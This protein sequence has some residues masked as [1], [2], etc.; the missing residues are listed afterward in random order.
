MKRNIKFENNG[1]EIEF[2]GMTISDDLLISFSKCSNKDFGPSPFVYIESKDVIASK[3]FVVELPK[4]TIM[5]LKAIKDKFSTKI[6]SLYINIMNG[7]EEL[8]LLDLDNKEYPYLTTTKTI[9]EE[10]EIS[11]KYNKALEFVFSDKCFNHYKL[12]E[13][14]AFKD[15]SD[16]Q[17]RIS[18]TAKGMN[19]QEY[20]YE[21]NK[22][23]YTTFKELI[24]RI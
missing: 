19:L 9:L 3:K 24:G 22:V 8:M 11:P 10:G 21:G 13:S 14:P 18:S 23:R 7:S 20:D 5:E 17:R 12:G 4:E 1:K 2:G 16:L 6:N 15:F